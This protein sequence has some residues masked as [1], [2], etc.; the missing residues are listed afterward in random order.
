M[1][2]AAYELL[3]L[4]RHEGDDLPLREQSLQVGIGRRNAVVGLTVVESLPKQSVQL[5]EEC[6]VRRTEA[7]NCGECERHSR[8]RVLQ[9]SNGFPQ[10]VSRLTFA[11]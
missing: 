7:A 2:Q 3:A 5:A 4:D 1:H 11:K 8:S 10:F 9:L 6:G